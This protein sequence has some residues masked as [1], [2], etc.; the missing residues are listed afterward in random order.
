MTP[1]ER[2]YFISRIRSGFYLVK[3]GQSDVRILTPTSEDEFFANQVFMDSFDKCRKDEL[4]T[5]EE[6]F[7]WLIEKGLWSDEKDKKI[8]AIEKE[9][10]KLK[11][12]I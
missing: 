10:E 8:D 4:M 2:E 12:E 1:Y 5:E 7:D 3:L 9:L 6:M 11:I